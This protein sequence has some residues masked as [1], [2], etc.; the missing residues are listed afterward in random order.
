MS[1]GGGTSAGPRDE[2]WM[3][4]RTQGSATHHA[5][6][7][8]NQSKYERR[9]HTRNIEEPLKPLLFNL[10]VLYMWTFVG[11]HEFGPHACFY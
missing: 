7:S 5:S 11:L 1:W 4:S 8:V 10:I 6:A 3:P 9:H 2:R